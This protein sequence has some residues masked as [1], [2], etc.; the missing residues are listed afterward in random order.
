MFGLGFDTS[1]E[2]ALLGIS[3]IQAAQGTSIWLILIFPL[4]FTA[5]MCLLDTFDGAAMM[6]L[7]TSAKLAKDTIAVLYYQCVLTAITVVVALVIGVLQLLNLI[8]AVR[9]NLSGPFWDGVGVA[10][11][12]YDIIGGGICGSF[13]VFGIL[14]VLL[15][16]PWRRRVDRQR[17]LRR[18]LAANAEEEDEIT[19]VPALLSDDTLETDSGTKSAQVRITPD[20]SEASRV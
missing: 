16:G 11:D 9:P 2:I 6:S 14:S 4:L 8:L 10:G 5:G 18:P 15:Y 19:V 1:S 7:Y 12:H 3:S 17:E 20:E 13:L